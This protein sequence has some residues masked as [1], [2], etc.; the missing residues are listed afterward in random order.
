M[1]EMSGGSAS[2]PGDGPDL[3]VVLAGLVPGP[4]LAALLD[5]AAAG[6][7]GLD[8]FGLVE[9]AAA[10]ER[11]AAW[12]TALQATAV[13]ELADRPLAV[14]GARVATPA[15]DR[16]RNTEMEL[17]A[18][19]RISPW[20]ANARVTVATRLAA[21][22]PATLAALTRGEIDYLRARTLAEATADL[23]P[24]HVAA[25]EE[26]V[27]PRAGERTHAEHRRAVTRAVLAI[28]PRGAEERHER[29]RAGRRVLFAPA[30]DGMG[31][32]LAELPADG[33]AAIR[34]AL[35][36]AAAGMKTAD[37][38]DART[39]DQRRADALVA[40]ARTALDTGHL[41]GGPGGLRL[42]DGQGRRP[43]IQVTVPFTTLL[44]LDDAPATLAGYGPIPASVARRIA[45]D[46]VWRRLLTDPA[47]GAL[48]DY[49]STTYRPPQD[50]VDHVVARDR[51]CRGVACA[52]PAHQCD[53]D[54]TVPAPAGPT[55]DRN[56]APLCR[57]L[58]HWAKTRRYWRLEQPEAGRF[59]WTS[60][61]GHTYH[62]DPEPVGPI[63][64][65]TS[66]GHPARV[67]AWEPPPWI[68]DPHPIDETLTPD[69][70]P[71][72]LHPPWAE[73]LMSL[74][75]E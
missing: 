12:A 75:E 2:G 37:P 54:H 63:I 53:L 62:L 24:A 43:A 72:H 26:R 64:E 19:L 21:A 9:V 46:G 73:D 68:Q 65:P 35:D 70:D 18:R 60:N 16:I 34:C 67:D 17:A 8:G 1:F 23:E 69:E 13:A 51:T 25:V 38:T 47:S 58:D 5:S 14:D 30:Q 6:L 74:C 29:G 40:M 36:A 52:R 7:D 22:L 39:V 4:G 49:G 59:V 10:A 56:L 57:G 66:R 20:A 3:G 41:G 45:A 27:L 32:L 50:L 48:L 42:A 55:A 44:G 11:L 33:L 71:A 15:E 61:T 28:D 31:Q